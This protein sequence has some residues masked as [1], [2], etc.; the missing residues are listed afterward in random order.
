MRQNGMIRKVITISN[1]GKLRKCVSHG[2]TTFKKLNLI[3]GENA[4]G[5]TT[6]SS[7]LRSL[8]T[9]NA[10]YILGR[11][12]LHKSDSDKAHVHIHIDGTQHIFDGRLWNKTNL[13]PKI[14]IF[15]ESF[16]VDNVYSGCYIDPIQREN[17]LQF[18][19]GEEGV[20]YAE[21]IAQLSIDIKNAND[22]LTP[23]REKLRE[24]ITGSLD[25][26][27]FIRASK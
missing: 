21:A 16:V 7:I 19:V 17:L 23:L 26:D 6:L 13:L 27:R 1:V 4:Q 8:T 24:K 14:E 5:K 18:I 10:E 12:T 9:G 25:V 15:D 3:F 11:E 22:R 2:D 20:E